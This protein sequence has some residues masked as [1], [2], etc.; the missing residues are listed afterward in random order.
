MFA[1]GGRAQLR[2]RR[3]AQDLTAPLSFQL[4]LLGVPNP[5][6]GSPSGDSTNVDALSRSG[7]M[8]LGEETQLPG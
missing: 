6:P 2:V 7:A 5:E 8:V 1:D 3:D 4:S